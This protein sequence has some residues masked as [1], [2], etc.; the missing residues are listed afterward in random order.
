MG[1]R[2]MRIR[3]NIHEGF[4]KKKFMSEGGVGRK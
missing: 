1:L 2:K 4:R 3:R